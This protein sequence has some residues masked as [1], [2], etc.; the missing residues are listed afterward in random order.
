MSASDPAPDTATGLPPRIPGPD[1]P[2]AGRGARYHVL[3][4][5]LTG[6]G[7]VRARKRCPSIAP[8]GKRRCDLER[9]H[10]GPHAAGDE[11]IGQGRWTWDGAV[12]L[13]PPRTG[14]ATDG[15]P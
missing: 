8:A 4:M 6:N 2:D 7:E 5:G 1:D 13:W 14:W 9:G 12:Y 11:R 10:D 3:N 15:S